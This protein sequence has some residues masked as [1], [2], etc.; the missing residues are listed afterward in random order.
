M[1]GIEVANGSE[2]T[3]ALAEEERLYT[4]LS[5]RDVSDAQADGHAC[6]ASA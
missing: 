6:C 3:E 2:L 4:L 5:Q 1:T